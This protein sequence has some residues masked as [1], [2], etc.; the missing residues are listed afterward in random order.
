MAPTAS[1]LIM[2]FL[3]RDIPITCPFSQSA[4]RREMQ[5]QGVL[6]Y[7]NASAKT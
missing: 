5:A 1:M 3:F 2:R 6:A 4:R 7:C